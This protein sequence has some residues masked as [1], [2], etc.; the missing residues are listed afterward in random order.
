MTSSSRSKMIELEAKH[1]TAGRATEPTHSG[2][3]CREL[4]QVTPSPE[5]GKLSVQ[6][7]VWLTRENNVAE[8]CL[9]SEV[10]L[11][12][13][14]LRLCWTSQRRAVGEH[15]KR[16][17][18]PWREA[19]AVSKLLQKRCRA[20]RLDLFLAD[21]LRLSGLIWKHRAGDTARRSF[22]CLRAE[23]PHHMPR[24]LHAPTYKPPTTF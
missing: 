22:H 17:Q 6:A 23:I 8:L 5:A 18:T 10:A 11:C 14:A 21:V 19:W 1:V 9:K 4:Q 2:L 24:P 13:Y 15:R 16:Q 20:A 7:T 12:N 3:T